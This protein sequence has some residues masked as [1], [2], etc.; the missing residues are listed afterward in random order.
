M[1]A[2][3]AAVVTVLLLVASAPGQLVPAGSEFQVN[4]YTTDFQGRPGVASQPDGFVVLWESTGGVSGQRFDSL[5]MQLGTEFQVSIGTAAFFERPSVASQA[6][7]F[8]VAGIAN[9]GSDFGVFGRRFDSLGMATGSA[10]QVNSYTSN[11]Q[12]QQAV[13]AD[14]SGGFVVWSSD[15]QD[16]SE[17]GVFGQ[18]LDS[19]GTK[20]GSEFQVNTYTTGDQDYPAVGRDGS[21]GFV[22][23]WSSP[24]DGSSKGVFAQRFDSSGARS[25]TEFQVN[26]YTSGLQWKPDIE[27]LASGFVVV[28]TS[29]N[30]HDGDGHGVF[31]QRFDS[32]GARSGTEFQVNTHTTGGQEFPLGTTEAS[33]CWVASDGGGGFLVVWTSTPAQDGDE[34][35]VFAQHFDSAGAPSGTEFRVNTYTTNR[36]FDPVVSG[37]GA[38]GFTVAW[39]SYGQDGDTGGIFAQRLVT[40]LANGEP[41]AEAARCMTTNCVDGVCCDTSCGN[42]ME[43]CNVAGSVGTC[44][45]TL[46]PGDPCSDATQ[47]DSASCTD[48]VCCNNP[49]TGAMEACNVVGSVGMCVP[50]LPLGDACT[51][52]TECE[53]TFCAD[54]VCCSQECS[55]PGQAC[56]LPQLLGTCVATVSPAPLVSTWGILGLVASLVLVAF[57]AIRRYAF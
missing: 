36:Q 2:T 38:G 35:G 5:G 24:Q 55:E 48:G 39:V 42:P 53:S 51:A 33:P 12:Y 25:G 8:V 6:D 26:T 10:F 49:C 46:P 23:V 37:D 17:H 41:C 45:P 13:A 1:R 54:G 31:G 3:L 4:T 57:L 32:S 34:D 44:T 14:G 27:K 50:T 7:G 11:R 18:R 20:V 19:L 16:G 15:L 47:C 28:W 29:G 43:A 30:D 52:S 56:N 40:P 9:D 22:V 21:G